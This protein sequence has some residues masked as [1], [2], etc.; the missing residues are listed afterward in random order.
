MKP[1]TE[2]FFISTHQSLPLSHRLQYATL[3]T[4]CFIFVSQKT[5]P[6]VRGIPRS[7]RGH[8]GTTTRCRFISN[9]LSNAKVIPFFKFQINPQILAPSNC[10]PAKGD[11]RSGGGAFHKLHL[12]FPYTL[13][14]LKFSACSKIST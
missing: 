4:Y 14:F 3:R 1:Y 5:V 13:F 10:P 7:G 12:F 11:E 9:L 2:F 6:L 8:K